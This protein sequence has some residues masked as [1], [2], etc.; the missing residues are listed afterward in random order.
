MRIR[1]VVTVALAVCV[2]GSLLVPT[3]TAAPITPKPPADEA[4]SSGWY[5]AALDG[6]PRIQ[7][8]SNFGYCGETSLITAG[9]RYGQY[10]S[11]WTAREM[12]TPGVPQTRESSQL[13]LGVNAVKAAKRMKLNAVDAPSTK[14]FSRFTTWVR[15]HVADGDVVMVGMF[16]NTR[17]LGEPG[18]GDSTYDHI[19]PVY[20]YESTV[21][22]ASGQAAAAAPTDALTISDN[23]LRTVGNHM[24]M[25]YTY[26]LSDVRRTRAEANAPGSPVYSFRQKGPWYATAVT[27]PTDP[28]DVLLPVRLKVSKPSEGL[29][30]Q[31]VMSAPPTPSPIVL[32]VTVTLP[33]DP[34]DVIVYEYDSFAD[35]PIRDFNANASQASQLWVVPSGVGDY[36]FTVDAMSSD[37]RVYR[38]VLSTAP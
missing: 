15:N 33:K 3:A 38:A 7:W 30:N 31:P 23:G 13:L 6:A 2:A 9:L 4:S 14:N 19:V 36:S 29:R 18:P 8:N 22:L 21:P 25:L 26:E 35:V 20:G 11:Q 24:P 10:T 12:A 5:Q 1:T 37:T 27:G 32:T 17:M 34:A 16:N 28:T